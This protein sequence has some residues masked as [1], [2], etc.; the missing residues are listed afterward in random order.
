[1]TGFSLSIFKE[2]LVPIVGLYR[3]C[4]LKMSVTGNRNFNTRTRD[5]C[6]FVYDCGFADNGGSSFKWDSKR[7]TGSFAILKKFAKMR[8]RSEKNCFC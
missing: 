2:E 4:M 7:L 8:I 6:L 1:M 3:V 5:R